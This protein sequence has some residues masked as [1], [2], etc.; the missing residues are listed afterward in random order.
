MTMLEVVL[1]LFLL[2]CAVAAAVTKKLLVTVVI[3]MGYS[4]VMSL[5]WMLLQS[6]DL[7]ITEAAVGAGV[8]SLLFSSLC[9]R[10]T[11]LKR[12]PRGRRSTMKSNE[13]WKSWLRGDLD[14]TDTL[15]EAQMPSALEPAGTETSQTSGQEQPA[16]MKTLSGGNCICSKNSIPFSPC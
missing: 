14:L 13:T 10:L 15:P 3:F 11:R 8:T 7:A 6:P 2:V 16:S 4:L 5:I 12:I 9:A 1:L